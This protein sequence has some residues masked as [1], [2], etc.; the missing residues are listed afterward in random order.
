MAKTVKVIPL[1]D[2][3]YEGKKR[4]ANSE[5]FDMDEESANSLTKKG[6]VKK[7]ADTSAKK[8]IEVKDGVING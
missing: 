5:P 8:Q 2:I 1:V 6:I 4:P 3:E 7:V